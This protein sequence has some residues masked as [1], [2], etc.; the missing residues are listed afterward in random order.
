MSRKTPDAIDRQLAK[1]LEPR[2]K[3][4]RDI[5][6][7]VREYAKKRKCLFLKGTFAG[8]D[9]F[10]DRLIITPRAIYGHMELKRP[11]EEPTVRQYARL[12]EL[13]AR[14]CFV[15][16]A[17]NVKDANAFIDELCCL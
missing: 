5:E 14:G 9:G 15:A 10:P 12:A 7:K 11:G 13:K 6:A 3:L 2:K 1:L 17:D 8:Q 16:W 4:E